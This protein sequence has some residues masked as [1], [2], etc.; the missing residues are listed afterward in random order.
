MEAGASV[1]LHWVRQAGRGKCGGGLHVGWEG[2]VMGYFGEVR[3]GY[4]CGH[5]GGGSCTCGVLGWSTCVCGGGVHWV[6]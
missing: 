5:V 4:V 1:G 6:R 3:R 2:R